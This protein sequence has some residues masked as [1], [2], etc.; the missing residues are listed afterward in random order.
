MTDRDLAATRLYGYRPA[1]WKYAAAWLAVAL[2][3]LMACA[4]TASGFE[5]EDAVWN[6]VAG[7]CF[8]ASFAVPGVYWLV[9]TRTDGRRV[10]AWA[11]RT[12][13]LS[14][15]TLVRDLPALFD[16]SGPTLPLLPHR[17]WWL[18]ALITVVL[19]GLGSW[20]A[21]HAAVAPGQL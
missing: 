18:V 19:A 21:G 16:A 11:Q 13:G 10:A 20:A 12:A 3:V 1:R 9:R 4:G 5:H 2:G 8:A 6:F 14:W 15:S 7:G 17:R